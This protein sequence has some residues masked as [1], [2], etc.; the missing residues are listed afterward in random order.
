MYARHVFRVGVRLKNPGELFRHW[1]VAG[2][3]FPFSALS[4]CLLLFVLFQFADKN[5][6]GLN[7]DAVGQDRKIHCRQ[8]SV[9]V[10]QR[11][12]ARGK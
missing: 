8:Y 12:T 3:A 4:F 9:S 5:P 7:E 6:E 1:F 2:G 10:Q 11:Q